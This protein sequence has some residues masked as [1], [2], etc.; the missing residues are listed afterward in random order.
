[1]NAIFEHLIEKKSRYRLFAPYV[2]L[3]FL[4]VN[5]F[6]IGMTGGSPNAYAHTMYIPVLIAAFYF[7][8]SVA[9]VT[10]IAAGLLIGPFM[11]VGFFDVEGE[12]VMNSLY[13][14]FYFAAIGGIMGLLFTLLQ[15][16]LKRMF[17]QN[18]ELNATL[19]SI[20]DG[21]VITDEKG[22]IER[23]NPM[24]LKLLGLKEEE[25]L[26]QPF[27]SI[28]TMMNF[29]TKAP[30]KDPI[31]AVL[32]KRQQ[33]QLEHDTVLKNHDGKELFIEDSSSPIYG[34]NGDLIG[35][36]LVFRDVS[37]QKDREKKI[38]HISYHDYLT[39]IPN[40]RYFQETLGTMNT[41][42]HYP[43]AVVMMDLN[44]LKVINDAYGH[45]QGNKALKAVAKA[46]KAVKRTEDFI[47]RIGGD[48][49]A[50]VLPNADETTMSTVK[51]RLDKF[52]SDITIGG[53][54][55]TLAFGYA[56][57]HDE[58]S[59]IREI[60]KE[61]EDQMYK[62]KVHSAQSTRNN[63]I[64][65]ILNTLT[66]KYQ[67][68]RLHSKRVA[69]YCKLIGE[70]MNL[71]S[72]EV[73]ELEFAGRL[74]DIGKISVPDKILKKPGPLNKDEWSVMVRHTVNGYQILRS[75]DQFS[76]LAEY[77]MS[78]HERI[79]GKGYPNQLQGKAIPLFARIIS[80]ADAFEAMISPRPYKDAMRA[81]EALKEL[82][83]H[84]GSQFD[85]K[86][87]NYFVDDVYPEIQ[88]NPR[89]INVSAS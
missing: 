73:S 38:L 82:K 26:N 17:V 45:E 71:R 83:K 59:R 78:H 9:V 12:P 8:P 33:V 76:Q 51:T 28:F 30:T 55:L 81:E 6:L 2:I 5:T 44:A 65:S 56:F 41:P 89:D 25:A 79:D 72:D 20:G 61:A 7:G 16:R 68:E 54:E 39:G 27:A 40:R 53:V 74:H 24:A 10:G 62:N 21:V 63:A 85:P 60:I 15:N 31:E 49:F 80:V 18:E 69:Y 22:T 47:A 11:L 42:E 43:L 86:I 84:A 13:R 58:K 48:E 66:D 3:A 77:A 34:K 88:N 50:M 19:M 57:K 52:I 29:K 87:V 67:E 46:L 32:K 35:A 37:R 1:M 4:I 70:K 23:I 75:A 36:V 64:L 14:T